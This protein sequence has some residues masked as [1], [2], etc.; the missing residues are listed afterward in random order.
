MK[1][2]LW[3]CEFPALN[4]AERSLLATLPGIRACGYEPVALAPSSGP[5]REALEQE[6]VEVVGFE[7]RAAATGDR[8]TQPELRRALCSVFTRLS[9]ALIHAN[10]LSMGRLCGP[11][12]V[13]AGLPI[14]AHLRDIV[15]M[16]ATAVA[17][18]NRC[19]R[20][21]A[22]SGAVRDFHLA[23]GVDASRVV[24]LYNG[25][26]L[27]AF[28]PDA[29]TG[30]LQRELGLPADARL[31]S[32]IGQIGL[33]KGQDVLVEALA[34]VAARH[35]DVHLLIVGERH[36]QKDEARRFEFELRDRVASSGFAE[37]VHWLGN[38]K[39]VACLLRELTLVAH[40]ARQ[41]PLGRVLLEAAASGC[42]TIATEVGGTAE[43]FP[44]SVNAGCLVPADDVRALVNAL[45]R[46]LTD[47]ALRSALGQRARAVAVERFDVGLASQKLAGAYDEVLRVAATCSGGV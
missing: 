16:S 10:S 9:P 38:R 6:H 44:A 42:A 21:F 31:I 36:S 37:R 4:G 45:D 25:V 27:G 41:E 30:Y 34:H 3:V 28:R 12:A 19:D 40:A 39:D 17:D 18:L 1:R 11:V 15:R 2:V 26:D 23:G 29:S 43:I 24:V 22:V 32:T 20:L 7:M 5:L 8:R 47:P 33:R 46:L 13:K 35:P 14:V